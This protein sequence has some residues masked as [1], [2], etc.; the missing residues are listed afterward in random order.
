[1][2]RRLA[3]HLTSLTL[4]LYAT[5]DLGMAVVGGWCLPTAAAAGP[6]S[7]HALPGKH[8]PCPPPLHEGAESCRGQC[9]DVQPRLVSQTAPHRSHRL[10]ASP[11]LLAGSPRNLA[12]AAPIREEPPVPREARSLGPL[13]AQR[14]QTTVVLIV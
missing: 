13:L 2:R 1:V 10:W 7:A 11:L 9:L 14:H 8:L 12:A 4:L 6:H 3:K 5:S